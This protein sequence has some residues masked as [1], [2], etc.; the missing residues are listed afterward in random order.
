M[1][2]KWI[3]SECGFILKGGRAVEV[4]SVIVSGGF[5]W[6]RIE[7]SL[8][9]FPWELVKFASWHPKLFVY[10]S[11]YLILDR[12]DLY[13]KEVLRFVWWAFQVRTKIGL[14]SSKIWMINWLITNMFMGLE[15]EKILLRSR[16]MTAARSW[17][18]YLFTWAQKASMTM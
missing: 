10:W 3:C 4:R 16:Y 11:I 8:S 15:R 2:W 5:H 18:R 17:R 7:D 13:W 6:G 9:P 12:N 1:Y 14:I